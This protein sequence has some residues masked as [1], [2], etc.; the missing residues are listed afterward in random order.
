MV[1]ED[2]LRLV[3]ENPVRSFGVLP[4]HQPSGFVRTSRGV[5]VAATGSR[6]AFFNEVL[7]VDDHVEL[8]VR[9]L[10]TALAG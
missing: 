3:H 7:P 10:L 8:Y 5:M 2:R 1:A 9:T 4:P 6:V